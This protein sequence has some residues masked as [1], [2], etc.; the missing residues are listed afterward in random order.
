MAKRKAASSKAQA[1]S[2]VPAKTNESSKTL[3]MIQRMEVELHRELAARLATVVLER[4][5]GHFAYCSDGCKTTCKGSCFGSCAGMC[6]KS[7]NSDCAGTCKGDPPGKGLTPP[8]RPIDDEIILIAR[9]IVYP[10]VDLYRE[11]LTK[12]GFPL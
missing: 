6:T 11:L 9:E 2:D 3:E 5:T 4:A 10:Y 7:C 12:H 8:E 1:S